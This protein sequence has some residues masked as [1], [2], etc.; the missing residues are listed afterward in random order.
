MG[1]PER[2]VSDALGPL[3]TV[4]SALG[5]VR[6]AS[7]EGNV[8][9][10]AGRQHARAYAP[11]SERPRRVFVSGG[12]GWEAKFVIAALEERGWTVD[13]DLFVGPDRDVRQGAA[14]PLDT[15]R[16]SAV[17]L[18]DS[19]AAERAR[20]VERFARAGGGVVLAGD[21]ESG[22]SGRADRRLARG[23]PRDRAPGHARGGYE[24][25][26]I[27]AGGARQRSRPALDRA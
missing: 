2:V 10:T 6:L 11:A 3:D 21:A 19:T 24:L 9:V 7:V 12:A 15:A 26:R 25:A 5:A 20:G 4:G 23:P 8:T 13:A 18:L 14:A 17:V 16:Y 1:L 22:K 27:V